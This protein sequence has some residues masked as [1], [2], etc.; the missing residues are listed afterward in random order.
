MHFNISVGIAEVISS[1]GRSFTTQ[2]QKKNLVIMIVFGGYMIQ[3]AYITR[4]LKILKILCW[5]NI[6]KEESKIMLYTGLMKV[7]TST[8]SEKDWLLRNNA[9]DK[10]KYWTIMIT[11]FLSLF[12]FVSLF[13]G[14]L[15]NASKHCKSLK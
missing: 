8:K 12:P 9:S 15:T 10:I 3:I 1:I 4:A 7:N 5:L 2:E 13:S 14:I 11:L 6:V